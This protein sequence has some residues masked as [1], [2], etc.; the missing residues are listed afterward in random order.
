MS[1][2]WKAVDDVFASADL[3]ATPA[4]VVWL[5]S[6]PSYLDSYV[7]ASRITINPLINSAL[8]ISE[9]IFLEILWFCHDGCAKRQTTEG[10][11]D[12]NQTTLLNEPVGGTIGM[13]RDSSL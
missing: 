10:I 7:L 8:Q 3:S 1:F 11:N 4:E 2:A 13:L 5:V 12:C 6:F 9:K